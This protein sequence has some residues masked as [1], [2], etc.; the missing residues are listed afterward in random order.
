MGVMLF[1]NMWIYKWNNLFKKTMK[2]SF[3]DETVR[4]SL[5]IWI[6][7]LKS[8]FTILEQ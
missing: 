4:K 2:A 6:Y 1:E 8:D 3:I 7:N 5:H